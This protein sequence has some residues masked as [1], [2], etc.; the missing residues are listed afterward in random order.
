MRKI[1][2]LN[3]FGVLLLFITTII[4]GS[5]FVV[6]K[7]AISFLPPL[8]VLC[9]RFLSSGILLGLIFFKKV[10]KLTLSVIFRGAL[11][12]FV[13]VLAYIIQTYGL[14][15]T[16]PSR[17]A[18]LTSTYVVIT[19]F[20]C[21]L[22]NG[23]KPFSYNVIS[24]ILCI[25]GIGF[26]SL[27]LTGG[28][29]GGV[30]VGD[31][32]TLICAVFFALQIIFIDK[33]QSKN[34]D[35]ISILIVELTTA[36]LV[37]LV[38]TLVFEIPYLTKPLAFDG[39]QIFNLVYL[40]FASTLFAQIFMIYGQKFTTVSEASL[41]MSL[42]AVFGTIFSLIFRLEV[43]TVFMVVGFVIIFISMIINE[44]HVDVLKPF[45]KIDKYK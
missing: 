10:L 31:I 3:L 17:N 33:S 39:N 32:L 22:V 14:M 27:P 12:G 1:T 25:V 26:V 34:D 20:L 15:Y 23:K 43:L 40:T 29:N 41:I 21:W 9:I 37:L 35:T 38:S 18:F 24:A 5:G 36:G 45:K 19:P 4:W 7:D 28:D 42:E 2:N 11:I 13:L 8:F 44:M 30:Y 6:L 16:T